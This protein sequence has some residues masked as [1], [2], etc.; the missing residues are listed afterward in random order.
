MS[1]A[2]RLGFGAAMKMLSGNRETVEAHNAAVGRVIASA[3][4]EHESG[5][6]RSMGENEGATL[7]LRFADGT[8]LRAW[9]D[10]QSCCEHRYMNT[11]DDLSAFAG[12]T[13]NG[14]E[15][16]E[17]PYVKDGEWGSVSECQFLLVNTD[18]GTFTV[19]NYNDHNGYYG[20][21][22]LEVRALGP[23]P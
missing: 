18:R 3:G 10:A 15:L 17:G 22:G 5:R 2:G 4:I 7:V 23:N 21:F 16:R 6:Y 11:D 12:A 8:G 19:A 9:D 1:E 20:G 14:M 13:F